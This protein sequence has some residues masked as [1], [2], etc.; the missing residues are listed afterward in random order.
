MNNK[1]EKSIEELMTSDYSYPS[2][3]Q[4]NL[5]EL[6]FRKRELAIHTTEQRKKLTDAVEKKKYIDDS[7]AKG[8]KINS[9]QIILSNFINPHTPYKGLLMFWGTGV[10]KTFG[11]IAIA[12]K[13]KPMVEKYGTKIH[14][15]VPGPLGKANYINEILNCIGDEYYKYFDNPLNE[16]KSII[17]DEDNLKKKCNKYYKSVLQYYD[18]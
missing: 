5:Q 2:P 16:N 13:F 4:E 3:S 6:L 1:D 14:V 12:E 7:C 8:C 17:I 10:G 15:L 9:S 11:S 18:T